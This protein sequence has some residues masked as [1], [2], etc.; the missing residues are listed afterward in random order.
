MESLGGGG[1]DW[2]EGEVGGRVRCQGL[3]VF[4]VGERG[5]RDAWRSAY[6]SDGTGTST[7]VP[8]DICEVGSFADGLGLGAWR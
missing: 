3:S 6:V 1:N 7:V 8:V 5:Q 2:E 4:G